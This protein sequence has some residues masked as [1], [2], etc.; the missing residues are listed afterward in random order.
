[1]QQAEGTIYYNINKFSPNNKPIDGTMIILG[2]MR[3]DVFLYRDQ[4]PRRHN[5]QLIL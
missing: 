2:K 5:L 3:Y 1:M 4:V